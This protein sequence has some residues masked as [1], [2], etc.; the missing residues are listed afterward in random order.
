MNKPLVSILVPT[1]NRA[2]LIGE[3]L[4][5]I[6]AQTYSNWECIIVDDGSIDETKTVVQT[7]CHKDTRFQYH[8]RP[9]NLPKGGNA[10]RNYGFELSKGEFVNWFDDDDLMHKEFIKTKLNQFKE[11]HDFI[12]TL[13]SIIDRDN[14]KDKIQVENYQIGNLFK[15]Y[16]LWK[17]QIF[18]PNALFKRNFLIDKKLFSENIIRGQETEF[19]SRIF[20]KTRYKS[21][22]I[23]KVPLFYYRQHEKTKSNQSRKYNSNF[24]QS[25]TSIFLSNLKRSIVLNDK[26]L[27]RHCLNLVTDVF[28]SALKNKDISL[29]KRIVSELFE[30]SKNINYRKAIIAL[31]LG[32]LIINFGTIRYRVKMIFKQALKF[33]YS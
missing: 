18:T 25:Q 31:I 22:K 33:I 29:S 2:N 17:V 20:F 11:N 21:F 3:T 16:L 14:L 7:Y 23:I 24:K 5:S 10:A 4:D 19:F 6:M 13:G 8:K 28:F 1:Y 9:K 32:N 26:E 27:I 12:L 15:D 30:I